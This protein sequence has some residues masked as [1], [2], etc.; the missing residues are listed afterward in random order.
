MVVVRQMNE[1]LDGTECLDTYGAGTGKS[2]G[3][4][5]KSEVRN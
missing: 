3:P 4:E 5:K 1:E 2:H